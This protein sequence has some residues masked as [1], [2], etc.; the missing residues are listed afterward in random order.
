MGLTYSLSNPSLLLGLGISKSKIGGRCGQAVMASGWE[1]EGQGSKP[2][3][4]KQPKAPGC[5]KQQKYSQ[6]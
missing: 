4:S 3:P 5:L 1:S 2:S 6:P